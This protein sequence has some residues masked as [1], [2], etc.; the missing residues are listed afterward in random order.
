[1]LRFRCYRNLNR[2]PLFNRRK[3]GR[4]YSARRKFSGRRFSGGS[5]PFC[6]VLYTMRMY[7]VHC[8]TCNRS[9]VKKALHSRGRGEMGKR[10]EALILAE[11][12]VVSLYGSWLLQARGFS[13]ERT[14]SLRGP[15]THQYE[16]GFEEALGSSHSHRPHAD[17]SP[18]SELARKCRRFWVV[19]G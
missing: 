2:I 12:G 18:G 5:M 15:R 17:C 16:A 14:F 1:M 19:V 8:P 3:I 10:G 7:C 6:L 13:P 11:S 9:S 4:G